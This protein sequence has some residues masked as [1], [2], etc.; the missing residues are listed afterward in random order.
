MI[1]DVEIEMAKE[2]I[3]NIKKIELYTWFLLIIFYLNKIY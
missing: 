2:K 3:R 1:L